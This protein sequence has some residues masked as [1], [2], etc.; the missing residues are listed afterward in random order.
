MELGRDLM[1]TTDLT[2]LGPGVPMDSDPL[3]VNV[4]TSLRLHIMFKLVLGCWG[5]TF[6]FL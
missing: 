5:Y 4:A 2:E 6:I 1:N 3:L